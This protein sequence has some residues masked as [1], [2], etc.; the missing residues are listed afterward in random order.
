MIQSNKKGKNESKFYDLMLSKPN[1]NCSQY[2]CDGE[3]HVFTWS[4]IKILIKC[5]TIGPT[6]NPVPI[7]KYR[8][9][10]EP[11][12]NE[13]NEAQS[14]LIYKGDKPYFHQISEYEEEQPVQQVLQQQ[15]QQQSVQKQQVQQVQNKK[16]EPIQ[17]QQVLNPPKQTNK[18]YMRVSNPFENEEDSDYD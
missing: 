18:Q 14:S 12:S 15:V 4:F 5:L 13:K 16:K 9:S 1:T 10:S 2:Y 7:P 8:P 11:I 6:P 17:R 3:F